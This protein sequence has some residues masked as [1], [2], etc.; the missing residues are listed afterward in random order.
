[1]EELYESWDQTFAWG[2]DVSFT[3][4]PRQYNESL[5]NGCGLKAVGRST[6]V[7]FWRARGHG[8]YVKL[9]RQTGNLDLRLG[10]LPLSM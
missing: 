2:S 10:A 6:A 1:M 4:F 3:N 7:E 5:L 8:N 9:Q